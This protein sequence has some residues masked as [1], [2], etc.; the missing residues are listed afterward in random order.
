M[1]G[2]NVLMEHGVHEVEPVVEENFP[3]GQLEQMLAPTAVYVPGL[4]LVHEATPGPE[5]VPGA[6]GVQEEDP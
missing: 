5:N 1:V 3:A 6:H 4:Q 2:A